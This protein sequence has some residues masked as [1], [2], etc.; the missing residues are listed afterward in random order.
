MLLKACPQK[1]FL[2]QNTL[3]GHNN[4]HKNLVCPHAV[5]WL[6]AKNSCD[7]ERNGG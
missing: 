2:Y 7:K 6:P 4:I 5:L 3:K 1:S